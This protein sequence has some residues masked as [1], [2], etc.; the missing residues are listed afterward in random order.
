VSERKLKPIRE[1]WKA[2]RDNLLIP[3]QHEPGQQKGYLG[4][5]KQKKHIGSEHHSSSTGG[6]QFYQI[7][8]HR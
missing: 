7:G 5:G 6:V 1:G 8:G 4:S 3:D 2:W